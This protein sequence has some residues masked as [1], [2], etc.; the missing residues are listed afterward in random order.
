MA[1]GIKVAK[2]M[3]GN[4]IGCFLDMQY[5]R[6]LISFYGK[7]VRIALGKNLTIIKDCKT[8][9]Q[10]ERDCNAKI[11]ALFLCLHSATSYIIGNSQQLM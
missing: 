6:P 7:H 1:M 3:K 4:V 5:I 11:S 8:L 2:E 10:E 9:L